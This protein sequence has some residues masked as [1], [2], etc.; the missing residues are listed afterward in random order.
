[1]YRITLHCA[2]S[3]VIWILQ[4]VRNVSERWFSRLQE[5]TVHCNEWKCKPVLHFICIHKVQLLIHG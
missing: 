2:V 4:E 5:R 1:M 3:E